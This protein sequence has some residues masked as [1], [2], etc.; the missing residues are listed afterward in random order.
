[1]SRSLLLFQIVA[2]G[3]PAPSSFTTPP[4]IGGLRSPIFEG[5]MGVPRFDLVV[6]PDSSG[7]GGSGGGST[8]RSDAGENSRENVA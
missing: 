6:Q 7:G 8:G 1:M 4:L 2:S 3:T 5:I